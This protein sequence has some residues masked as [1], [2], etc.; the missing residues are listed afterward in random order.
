MGLEV[1]MG[2]ISRFGSAQRPCFFKRFALRTGLF[3]DVGRTIFAAKPTAL[4][5]ARPEGAI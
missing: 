3:D 2:P 1:G 5:N 4:A